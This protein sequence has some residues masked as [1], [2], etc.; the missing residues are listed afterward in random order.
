M[1]LISE[2]LRAELL[3]F[4]DAIRSGDEQEQLRRAVR[5][6]CTENF[7]EPTV[8][9]LMESD[10]PFD[11]KVWVRLGSELGVLGLSVPE[12]DGGV[13]GSLVDQAVADRL[14]S[15]AEGYEERAEQPSQA[16]AAGD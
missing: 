9:R 15:I 12:A 6:F 14:R 1:T 13:G 4:I 11:P 3:A 16:D 8:R 2:P 7:D 5:R 10:P